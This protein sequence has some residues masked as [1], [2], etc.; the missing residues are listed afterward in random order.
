MFTI[1]MPDFSDELHLWRSQWIIIG[2]GKVCFEKPSFTA[3]ETKNPD[4]TLRNRNI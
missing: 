3:T 4:K 1:W 2:K